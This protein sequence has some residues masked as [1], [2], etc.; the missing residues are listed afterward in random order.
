MPPQTA[1]NEMAALNENRIRLRQLE[2]ES[3][4]QRTMIARPS[5]YYIKGTIRYWEFER[6]GMTNLGQSSQTST[7]LSPYPY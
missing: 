7:C 5:E 1:I 3:E 6:M 4:P 2:N